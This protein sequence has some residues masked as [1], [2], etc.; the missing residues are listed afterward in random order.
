MQGWYNIH[1][2]INVTHHI[3]KMKDKNHII[4]S[5]DAEKTFDKFQHPFMIRVCIFNKLLSESHVTQKQGFSTSTL[6]TVWIRQRFFVGGSPVHCGMLI[7]HIPDCY[8]LDAVSDPLPHVTTKLSPDVASCP[9]RSKIS[10]GEN[11]CSEVLRV[12]A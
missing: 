10:P 9:L 7:K 5:I 12:T 8:S 4:I 2:S 11:F 1:K 3:S 6:L